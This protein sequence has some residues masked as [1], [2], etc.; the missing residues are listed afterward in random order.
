MTFIPGFTVVLSTILIGCTQAL[1]E[2]YKGQIDRH[3]TFLNRVPKTEVF[4]QI[5]I[6]KFLQI[7]P[8]IGM[9]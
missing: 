7:L 4:V 6:G 5:F 1:T 8:T 3:T 2:T 9:R